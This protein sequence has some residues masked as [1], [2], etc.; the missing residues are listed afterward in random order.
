MHSPKVSKKPSHAEFH[1]NNNTNTK[2]SFTSELVKFSKDNQLLKQYKCIG[3]TVSLVW[4]L[5][6]FVILPSPV[7]DCFLS[8]TS[9]SHFLNVNITSHLLTRQ[10]YRLSN[11]AGKSS[12]SCKLSSYTSDTYICELAETQ[13]STVHFRS[14]PGNMPKSQY[15]MSSTA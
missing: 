5:R 14:A 13:S 11:V 10:V 9:L 8:F 3:P 6:G 2:K 7:I 12:P 4:M 1:Q 15:S